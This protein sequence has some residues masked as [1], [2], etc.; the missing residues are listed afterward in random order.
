[1][2]TTPRTPTSTSTLTTPPSTLALSPPQTPTP[3]AVTPQAQAIT[4]EASAPDTTR[5]TEPVAF[6][7]FEDDHTRR[8]FAAMGL[9]TRVHFVLVKRALVLM[10]VTYVPMALLAL[11][12]GLYD[13]AA[14]PT[15][16][17]ADFAAYAQFLI[18][19]PLY[20]VAE[21]I[22]EGSTREAAKQ[23]L[24][25]G[26]VRPADAPQVYGIHATLARA[27]A[28]RWP[29]LVCI[30]CAYVF[31]LVI[32]V[33]QF[34]ADPLP[35]WHVQGDETSRW[36]TA[37]GVWAFFVSIPLLNFIW[38]RLICKI[39]LWIYYLY[40]ITRLH[41]ELHPM[42]ADA[43]GGIGFVSETQG[44]Y[45][46]FIL[47]FGVGNVAAPVGYQVVVLNYDLSILPVWGPLVLFGLGAPI[48][49]TLPLLMFTKQLYRSKKR[50]L[51]AYRERVTEQSRRVEQNWLFGGRRESPQRDV[52]ELAELE[53]LALL[54]AR[55]EKMRVVPFDLRSF[56][57]LIGSSL[58]AVATLLPLLYQ[59]GDLATIVDAISQLVG[60]AAGD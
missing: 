52:R 36:M 12:Q 56:G 11:L 32:L 39:I 51:A 59:K 37:A 31:S 5:G 1:M 19:L 16:F 8:F 40:R 49:F 60:H 50:A 30:G 55:I 43:T 21:P 10:I 9:G 7:L 38:L 27:R 53:T 2:T 25:C 47:A 46:L 34:G 13:T 28:A 18:A 48:L 54:F 14:T 4:G 20:I 29:D 24:A 22:I 3:A 33:P 44:R 58:G 23:F 45:A 57:Q 42:H 35:T 41:L 17:F 15:N 6:S 26:V